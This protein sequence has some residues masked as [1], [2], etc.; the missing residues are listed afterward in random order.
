MVEGC[1]QSDWGD[2][3]LTTT[4]GDGFRS[5]FEERAAQ[6]GVS[7]AAPFFDALVHLNTLIP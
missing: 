1:G 6:R 7:S 3:G 4:W 5:Q 2:L